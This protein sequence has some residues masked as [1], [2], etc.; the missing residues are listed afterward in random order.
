MSTRRARSVSRH[1]GLTPGR[2]MTPSIYDNGYSSYSTRLNIYQPDIYYPRAHSVSRIDDYLP[3]AASVARFNNVADEYH[4]IVGG[5]SNA[6]DRWRRSQS[7]HRFDHLKAQRP[8]RPYATH[9]FDY[10]DRYT[11]RIRDKTPIYLDD[12][13]SHRPYYWYH[14]APRTHYYY[15]PYDDWHYRPLYNYRSPNL[16]S[17]SGYDTTYRFNDA[18]NRVGTMKRAMRDIDYNRELRQL[19]FHYPTTYSTLTHADHFLGKAREDVRQAIRSRVGD[20]IRRDNPRDYFGRTF[21]QFEKDGVNNV[22]V[23]YTGLTK[24]VDAKPSYWKAEDNVETGYDLQAMNDD[25]IDKLDANQT[26]IDASREWLLQDRAGIA[27]RMYHFDM[28]SRRARRDV[29]NAQRLVRNLQQLKHEMTNR[30]AQ[31]WTFTKYS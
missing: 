31:P 25:T 26:R 21:V 20:G 9:D 27:P 12:H 24:T 1:R 7:V 30:L 28:D 16:Y 3:R 23:K 19:R 13:Y 29:D 15:L 18:I 4:S 10:F 11:E 22:G 2:E 5:R 14:T 8:Y 17:A 6:Y